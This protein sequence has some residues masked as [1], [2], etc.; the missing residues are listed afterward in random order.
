MNSSFRAWSS[1]SCS[2]CKMAGARRDSSLIFRV[3]LCCHGP[4]CS[5]VK[6]KLAL[7]AQIGDDGSM[8]TLSIRRRAALLMRRRTQRFR[9]RPRTAVLQ[10]GQET[11]LGFVVGV[12]DIVPTMGFFAR[13]LTDACH[14][15]LS[16]LT[17][18]PCCSPHGHGGGNHSASPRMPAS[19]KQKA[20]SIRQNRRSIRQASPRAK[21]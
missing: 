8:P 6:L 10:V 7:G 15:A 2:W 3:R 4:R 12:G 1:C 16:G 21:P 13:D 11:T 20:R 14:E 5:S 9:S 18:D 17:T 19:P